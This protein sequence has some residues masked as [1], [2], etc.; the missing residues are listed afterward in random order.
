LGPTS[1]RTL[2]RRRG[3]DVADYDRL[4]SEEEV[5]FSVQDIRPSNEELLEPRS[6]VIHLTSEDVDTVGGIFEQSDVVSRFDGEDEWFRSFVDS[7]DEVRI[8][9]RQSA[10]KDTISA[11]LFFAQVQ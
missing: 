3:G 5:A 8:E 9:R 7:L 6:A 1:T 11:I 10:Q 4:D 2:S